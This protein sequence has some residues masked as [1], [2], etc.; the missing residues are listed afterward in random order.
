MNPPARSLSVLAACGFALTLLGAA[1][2]PK[3]SAP[4]PSLTDAEKQAGWKLLF[5][6]KTTTG[7]RLLGGDAFPKEAWGVENGCLRKLP[8]KGGDLVY[9]K[10]FEN[11]ELS[12]EWIVPKPNGNSGVKYRVQEKQGN[13]FAYGPEYQ[14]M[15]DGDVSDKNATGSLYDVL[16]PKGKKLKGPGEF[17]ES[18]IV[19][20][21]DHVEHWLNGVK[22]VEYDVGSAAFN[23]GIARSKFKN[24]PKFARDARG[25]VDLQDHGDEIWFR[26]IKIRELS[27]K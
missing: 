15:A 19:V 26:N 9:E 24:D 12:F 17:N 1:S 18:R 3:P 16:P 14:L 27:A 4:P 21:G 8:G 10:Q 7:W 6:G 25:Y 13:S 5:D 11:F 23:A 22:V 2:P 20:N